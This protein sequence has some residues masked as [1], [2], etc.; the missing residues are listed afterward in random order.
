MDHP[1]STPPRASWLLASGLAALSLVAACASPPSAPAALPS[2]DTQALPASAASTVPSPSGASSAQPPLPRVFSALG[3]PCRAESPHEELCGKDGVVA[4][5][6][7][8]VDHA[9]DT[10]PP[11]AEVLLDERGG[12]GPRGTHT[13]VGAVGERLWVRAITCGGCRRIMGWAFVG[14]LPRLD[15]AQLLSLQRRLRLP[16]E[17]GPLRDVA[18]WRMQLRSSR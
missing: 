1:Y 8:P 6:I 4:G 14:D 13:T 17:L 3:G 7:V 11:V 2:V 9:L 16:A 18:A 5:V 10:P 15:D 12:S